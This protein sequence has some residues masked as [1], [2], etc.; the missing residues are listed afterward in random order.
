V[1]A[2]DGVSFQIQPGTTLGLIGESGSGKSVTARAIMRLLAKNARIVSGDILFQQPDQDPDQNAVNIINLDPKGKHI[3]TLRGGNIAMIFQEPMSSLTPVYSAGV[4]IN[5]SLQVHA[6]TKRTVGAQL[7]RAIKHTQKLSSSEAR[8]LAIHLL[9]RVGIP[10][11]AQSID[12]YP[13]QLS[14]GQRQQV[15]IAVALSCNPSLLI[16]D[17]PT[18]ALDVTTQS[19]INS[20]IKDIQQEYNMAV[21]YITHDLGVIAEVAQDVAV[22]Y[23]GRIVETGQVDDIFY[24]PKHPYT[25]SLLESIPRLGKVRG[26][27]LSTIRGMVPDPFSVPSGCP[28]HD[29]CP[30]MIPGKCDVTVPSLMH[31]TPHQQA[32]CLLYDDSGE[33]VAS[34]LQ[35]DVTRTTPESQLSGSQLDESH[36]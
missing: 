26:E 12:S 6:S 5:E 25:Q 10:R 32:A 4:H 29:R 20:L 27:R 11:A 17:E 35:A 9:D 30:Q 36:A 14:G 1:R 31:V 23:L 7:E 3:R 28:F 18:T 33:G 15:M 2:L 22:M 19:Q 34:S 24:A 16:A 13:H 8:K 21:L